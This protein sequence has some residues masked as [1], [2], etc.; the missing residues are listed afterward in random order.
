MQRANVFERQDVRLV[1]DLAG[2][3]GAFADALHH[4]YG[5]R[6][7]CI[8]GDFPN[9]MAVDKGVEFP[10]ARIAAA[11]G[12]PSV[13]ID[14][15]SFLPFGESTLDALHTSWFFHHGIP[16]TSLFEMYRVLRPGG[17]LIL[18]SFPA[19]TRYQMWGVY[20][21]WATSMRMRNVFFVEAGSIGSIQILQMPLT[22]EWNHGG[23]ART[24][25]LGKP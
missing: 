10:S 8:T 9:Q 7:V 3:V 6:I 17:F 5:D 11:K 22:K 13:V 25:A 2:S 12:L 16:W 18:R 24:S 20:R 4:F 19:W 21:E 23:G 14:G 1:F 15:T